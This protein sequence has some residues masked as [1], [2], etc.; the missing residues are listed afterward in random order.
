[1]NDSDGG[2]LNKLVGSV[3][4]KLMK[5]SNVKKENETSRKGDGSPNPETLV[6][7]SVEDIKYIA[8]I[9][10]RGKIVTYHEVDMSLLE[11]IIE[12]DPDRI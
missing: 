9:L 3:R 4:I 5:E 8:S 2:L 7:K 6:P 1:M 11:A 10:K 12:Y